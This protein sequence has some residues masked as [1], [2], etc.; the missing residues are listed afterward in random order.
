MNKIFSKPCGDLN[1]AKI[2]LLADPYFIFV[3][4]VPTPVSYNAGIV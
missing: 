3:L 1:N 4:R 2:E